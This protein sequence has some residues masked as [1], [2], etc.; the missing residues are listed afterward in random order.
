MTVED[1]INSNTVL[2][3]SLIRVA[4]TAQLTAAWRR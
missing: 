3:T 4:R 1:I 2:T